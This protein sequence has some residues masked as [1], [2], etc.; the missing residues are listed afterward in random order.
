MSK[1]LS[2]IVS[3]IVSEGQKIDHDSNVTGVTMNSKDVKEGNIFVAIKGIDQDGHDFIGQAIESGA[4]AIITNGRD[5]GKLSVPQ[6]KVANPRRAAS[7]IAAEFYEHPS[8]DLIVIG[9]TGTNGKTT[10][11]SLTKSILDH[12]GHKTAQIGTLGLIADGI[13]HMETLTTPD[14]IS[15]QRICAELKTEGFTHIVMEVSS[16]ALDQY[17]VADIKFNIAAFT[18]LSPE[19]LDYHSTIEAYFYAKLKLFTMLSFNSTAVVNMLDDYGKKIANQ[20]TA[21]VISFMEKNNASLFF[22]DLDV[23]TSGIEGKIFAGEKIYE[24]KSDLLGNFNSENIL[25]AVSICHALDVKNTHIEKGIEQ[26]SIIPGRMESYSIKSGAKV[27]IDYA[28]TPDA[29]EQVLKTLKKLL[30]DDSQLY[31][32]FG[33]GGERD[34]EKRPIMA[35]IAERYSS[36]CFITPDNPRKEDLDIINKEIKAGFQGFG[37]TIFTDRDLGVRKALNSAKTGDIVVILGKGREEYQEIDGQKIF[38]SDLEI[39]KEYQ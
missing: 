23:S 5:M 31:V 30:T 14:A 19:H 34:K 13:D 8:S 2:S 32:V 3:S 17:R 7:I 24:I 10:T 28:H 21:P 33:A 27:V 39:I 26:I 25:A 18:N 22:E 4:S 38:H 15:I 1:C 20:S 11:A 35:K 16:H 9:I 36:H 29:Y 37:Y 12:A 6:I